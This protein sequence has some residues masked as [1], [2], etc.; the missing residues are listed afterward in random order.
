V[1]KGGRDVADGTGGKCDVGC[2]SVAVGKDW[3]GVG[4]G[5][6]EDVEVYLTDLVLVSWLDVVIIR[7]LPLS[8]ITYL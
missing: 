3:G 8:L 1:G 6:E 5:E 2:R 4:P 7:R